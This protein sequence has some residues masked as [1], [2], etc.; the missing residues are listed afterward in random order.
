MVADERQEVDDAGAPVEERRREIRQL[1]RERREHLGLEAR[2]HDQ[3][4]G[5]GRR[6]EQ[7]LGE[8]AARVA[9]SV[10]E[11]LVVGDGAVGGE[12]VIGP[13]ERHLLERPRPRKNGHGRP[14]GLEIDEMGGQRDRR[15]R[16]TIAGSRM[17][18]PATTAAEPVAGERSSPGGRLA[19]RECPP[20]QSSVSAAS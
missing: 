11:E 18:A 10:V 7:A 17:A 2:V 1:R 6:R 14:E 9:G 15:Q 8:R 16:S 5:V 20:K 19:R 13:L 3:R 12:D 4:R